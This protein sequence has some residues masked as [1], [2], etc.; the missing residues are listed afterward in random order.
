MLSR[1]KMFSGDH[2]RGCGEHLVDSPPAVTSRGS[3]PRMRGALMVG[4]SLYSLL[5][6][7][8]ADAGSTA[9]LAYMLTL[10]GDHPRGCGEHHQPLTL[11]P[12]IG[13]SSPRMRGALV[14]A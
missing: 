11:R 6:I 13:G 4:C 12:R 2:P 5:G 9:K 1:V 10:Q 7:I 3:S 8:P 14:K